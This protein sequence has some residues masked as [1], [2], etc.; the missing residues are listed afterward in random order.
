MYPYSTGY[1]V[2]QGV[3][4]DQKPTLCSLLASDIGERTGADVVA[5]MHLQGPGVAV[6]TDTD[7][8]YVHRCDGSALVQDLS[9]VGYLGMQGIQA[10]LTLAED[11]AR[12]GVGWLRHA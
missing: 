12:A 7:G 6:M 9:D 2:Y 11:V 1:A 8:A 3:L 10:L 5:R 4:V